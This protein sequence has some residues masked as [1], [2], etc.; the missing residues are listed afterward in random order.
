[1]ID[2]QPIHET[3]VA[4]I[5]A[6]DAG[7]LSDAEFDEIYA[8]W[9]QFGVL[10]LRNQPVNENAL[11]AF[12]ARF[13]PLEEI[14]MGQRSDVESA[15][16]RNRYVLQLSN[17]IVD[18]KPIGGLGN[19][20]ANWHSDMT[21]METPP[22]ASVL[23]GVEIPEQGGDTYFADQV[24]AYESLPAELK[25]RIQDL[26]IKHDAAHT[27]T[28]ELRAGFD[29]FDDP[30]DAPGAIHPMVLR[31]GETGSAAL[32]LGRREWAYIPGLLLDESESLLD[33]IWSVATRPE[34]VWQQKWHPG[35]LIIWDNRRVLHRRDD[36]DPQ[37]R[38]LMKR[39]QVLARTIE[40]SREAPA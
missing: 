5:T 11:Q 10:R 38:R 30:R 34:F 37:S 7:H 40:S 14:P 27:S 39:C 21:Y 28:G 16:I 23:L 3:F 18:G 22:P 12:S 8:A 29:S 36:F 6:L 9:L 13:G 17:I 31:H 35:D 1:M 33:E 24:A 26:A 20:E 15:K 25:T 4:D 19:A 2:L 32:Y